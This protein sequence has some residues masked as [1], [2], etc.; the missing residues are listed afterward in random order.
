MNE[1][2]VFINEPVECD[3]CGKHNATKKQFGT[4]KCNLCNSTF[5]WPRIVKDKNLEAFDPCYIK[6]KKFIKVK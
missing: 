6:D 4:F 2:A 3:T 1:N 5:F